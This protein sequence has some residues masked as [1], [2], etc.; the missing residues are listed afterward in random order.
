[1]LLVAV[2]VA[3]PREL[4]RRPMLWLGGA[5]AAVI[6][7]PTLIWQK[8][9]GWP[10]LQMASVVRGEAEALYGGRAGIAVQLILFAG[11][12]GVALVGYGLWR[13]LRDDE[14]REYRFLA[15]AFVIL[16]V[17][18]VAAARASL[19]PRGP[20][21]AVGGRRCAGVCETTRARQGAAMAGVAS[22][23]VKHGPGG[24]RAGPFGDHHPL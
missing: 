14:M 11:V 24:R 7:S 9:H 19:L 1:M 21:C 10:Q 5:I 3:G 12:L 16:Y 6:A 13:L 17:M 20:V 8:V 22:G 2:A 4:L 18:F 23:C 15:V